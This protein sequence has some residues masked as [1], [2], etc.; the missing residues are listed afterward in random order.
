MSKYQVAFRLHG[1]MQISTTY[2]FGEATLRPK[3][4][5]PGISGTI[6]FDYE[7]EN[8]EEAK[9]TAANELK[10]K[11][12]IITGSLVFTTKEGIEVGN[13]YKI[14]RKD[15]GYKER[16]DTTLEAGGYE[17]SISEKIYDNTHGSIEKDEHLKRALNWYS[18][19]LSTKTAEDRLV[20]FWTGAESLANKETT[21]MN[22]SEDQRD[23]IESAKDDVLKE[24]DEE[25]DSKKRVNGHFGKL[26]SEK[27]TES[28]DEAV[29]RVAKDRIDEDQLSR[30]I[31]EIVERVYKSR[32]AIVHQGKQID[33]ANSKVNEAGQF[34]RELLIGSLSEPFADFVAE[35][36]PNRVN[37]PIIRFREALPIVF[38][39]DYEMELERDEIKKRL[40]ALTHDLDEAYRFPPRNFA[41]ED[42]PLRQVSENTFKLNPEFDF[43]ANQ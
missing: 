41:G 43:N 39:E 1:P 37:S 32:N 23:A 20:A 7:A 28:N 6:E 30:D 16:I 5:P 31:E 15:A 19:G 17:L 2:D 25:T 27:K 11:A 24:F 8:Q 40:F 3:K 12:R 33:D 38:G 29:L 26:L 14:T 10:E 18:Y 35:S 13:S 9:R 4:N 22:L 36:D 34:L 42:K 21:E